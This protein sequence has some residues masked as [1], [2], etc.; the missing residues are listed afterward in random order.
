MKTYE[1]M[2]E[3]IVEEAL[4]T[5]EGSLDCCM[6]EQCRND[7]AAYA[8]NHLPCRYV[9]TKSGGIISKADTMR[10]Q[11]LTDVRTTLIQAAQIVG[12]HPRH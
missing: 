3:A 12:Q 9:V 2:M 11:H 10:T 5:L 4:D 8:L 6:C 1:N 7:I